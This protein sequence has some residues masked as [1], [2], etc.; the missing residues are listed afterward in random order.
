MGYVYAHL[1]T[2]THTHIN[3]CEKNKPYYY[4]NKLYYLGLFFFLITKRE[5]QISGR[6]LAWHVSDLMFKRKKNQIG[7]KFLGHIHQ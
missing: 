2:H 4:R 5:T 1:Q 7:G 3:Q 6:V